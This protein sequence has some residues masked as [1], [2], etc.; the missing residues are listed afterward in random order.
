MN[1]DDWEGLELAKSVY[2]AFISI[3][4]DGHKIMGGYTNMVTA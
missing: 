3:I 1:D 4:C 2:T